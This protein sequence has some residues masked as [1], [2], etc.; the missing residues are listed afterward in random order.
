[1]LMNEINDYK[2]LFL[3]KSNLDH[4]FHLK[5]EM[6]CTLESIKD[7]C[8][9]QILRFSDALKEWIFSEKLFGVKFMP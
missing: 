5:Y 8:Y 6:L 1:M 4:K 3:R 9:Y 7:Y 2:W